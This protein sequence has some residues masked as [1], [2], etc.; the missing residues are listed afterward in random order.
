M[1]GQVSQFFDAV[2]AF[3]SSICSSLAMDGRVLL[4]AQLDIDQELVM[5]LNQ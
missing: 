2:V 1:A 4:S 5:H 3:W